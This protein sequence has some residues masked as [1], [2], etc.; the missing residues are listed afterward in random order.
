[1][2]TKTEKKDVIHGLLLL[3]T[4]IIWIIMRFYPRLDEDDEHETIKEDD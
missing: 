3:R 2:G 1:M 4:I